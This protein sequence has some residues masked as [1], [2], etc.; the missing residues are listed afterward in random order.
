M[1]NFQFKFC[2]DRNPNKKLIFHFPKSVRIDPKKIFSATDDILAT[3]FGQKLKNKGICYI[4]CLTNKERYA[5][6]DGV[7]NHWQ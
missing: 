3:E 6:M 5:N 2:E 7:Y 4:R 1:A